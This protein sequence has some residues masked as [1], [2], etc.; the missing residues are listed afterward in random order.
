MEVAKRGAEISPYFI[1]GFEP[2]E[3]LAKE[4]R[5]NGRIEYFANLNLIDGKITPDTEV[6]EGWERLSPIGVL[7][8]T[9]EGKIGTIHTHLEESFFSTLDFVQFLARKDTAMAMVNSAGD[10]SIMVKTQDITLADKG[11][12]FTEYMKQKLENI[13]RKNKVETDEEIDQGARKQ[14]RFIL[15]SA[16]QLGILVTRKEKEMDKFKIAK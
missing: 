9:P 11:Y 8:E 2:W 14:I 12:A 13:T 5:E 10:V 1:T 6:R 4:G 15:D 7:P 16:K 3:K